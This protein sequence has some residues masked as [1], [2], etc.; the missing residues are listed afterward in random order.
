[1][2]YTPP[3]LDQSLQTMLDGR[4]ILDTVECLAEQLTSLLHAYHADPGSF[5]VDALLRQ[6]SDIGCNL[7]LWLEVL[8]EPLTTEVA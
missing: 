1:M 6:L 2:T 5:D 7:E 3:E 8:Y 4:R